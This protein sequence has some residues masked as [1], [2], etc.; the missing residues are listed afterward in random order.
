LA[1]LA[2]HD[3]DVGELVRSDPGLNEVDEVLLSSTPGGI[4]SATQG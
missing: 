1:A 2:P 4:S 3:G